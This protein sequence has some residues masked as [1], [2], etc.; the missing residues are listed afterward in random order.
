MN[1]ISAEIKPCPFCG[2]NAKA[3]HHH[4][5]ASYQAMRATF[6]GLTSLD[7]RTLWTVRCT[8][9]DCPVSPFTSLEDDKENGIKRW[10]TRSFSS[11]PQTEDVEA[12]AEDERTEAAI[13]LEE[14][15]ISGDT[16]VSLNHG[17]HNGGAIYLH[18]LLAGYKAAKTAAQVPVSHLQSCLTDL[19][20]AYICNRNTESP[21]VACITP[22]G[23]P[24]YWKRAIEIVENTEK[25]TVAPVVP[26][27]PNDLVAS[28]QQKDVCCDGN[29]TN[30]EGCELKKIDAELLE[31]SSAISMNNMSGENCE[32]NKSNSD[33]ASV[34]SHPCTVGNS[35]EHDRTEWLK[36][37]MSLVRVGY[38]HAAT[39]IFNYCIN[40]KV[41]HEFTDFIAA[42]LN[43][44]NKKA[45]SYEM[46]E[47]EL[48]KMIDEPLLN[49]KQ[50]IPVECYM[51]IPLSSG[52]L[53]PREESVYLK[54][55]KRL[56]KGFVRAGKLSGKDSVSIWEEH[57]KL[58]E[59][60]KEHEEL[61][62]IFW[63]KKTTL[64]TK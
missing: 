15:N 63:L 40:N 3:V 39:E 46:F 7:A 37:M 11:A 13:Y 27:E 35:I 33:L 36:L 12:L 50:G 26:V 58:S 17:E 1:T 56:D 44:E 59:W 62:Y 60:N 30:A 19:V 31:F 16:M 53:P 2:G 47:S 4:Y 24:D 10:N 20:N 8:N 22:K 48:K 9:K 57:S 45:F 34:A 55:Y 41:S 54:G 52:D 64:Y 51:P 21:L 28:V 5:K 25:T 23:I 14:M 61:K 29:C 49:T 42:M 43:E 18:D 32:P 6:T 38:Q